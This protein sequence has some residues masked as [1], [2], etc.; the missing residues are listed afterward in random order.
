MVFSKLCSFPKR[1]SCGRDGLHAQ[2]M[3]DA[4][5]GPAAA[6]ANEVIQSITAI[7]NLLLS[8]SCPS[9]LGEYIAS[10]PLTPLLKPD[11]GVRPIAVGT[12]WRR[13]VSK[14]AASM[15]NKEM[16][17]YLGCTKVF[18]QSI[19]AILMLVL[20]YWVLLLV[21][22]LFFARRWSLVEPIKP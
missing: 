11:G 18:F 14:V 7:V 19:L 16:A 17:S 20:S 10:A 2:H 12:I 9:Q 5:T 4:L 6:I 21:R 15:V 8:G 13:L 3:L 1:T 22:I